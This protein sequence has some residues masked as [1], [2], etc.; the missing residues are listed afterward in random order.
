MKIIYPTDFPIEMNTEN[1]N[2]LANMALMVPVLPEWKKNSLEIL[3][4][5]QR[6]LVSNKISELNYEKTKQRLNSLTIEELE[7][8]KESIKINDQKNQL[9]KVIF[10]NKN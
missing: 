10:Y 1:L 3:T 9:L 5:E 8:V 2:I 6:V 7:E 4:D